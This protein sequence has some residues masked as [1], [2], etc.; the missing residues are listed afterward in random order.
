MGPLGRRAKAKELEKVESLAQ[1]PL[2][3]FIKITVIK[4]QRV[5]IYYIEYLLT[6]YVY[7]LFCRQQMSTVLS[8]RYTDIAFSDKWR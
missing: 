6:F 2:R 5:V 4:N 8:L 7:H 1:V 3:G